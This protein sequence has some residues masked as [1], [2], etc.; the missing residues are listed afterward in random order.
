MTAVDLTTPDGLRRMLGEAVKNF[1]AFP[2]WYA[3]VFSALYLP[4]LIWQ[5]SLV[6]FNWP[7]AAVASLTLKQQKQDGADHCART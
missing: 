3:T 7:L 1:A 2:G 4:L 6:V 5:Q